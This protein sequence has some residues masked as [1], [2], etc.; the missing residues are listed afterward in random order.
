ME[1]FVNIE[2]VV[3]GEG[4]LSLEVVLAPG[5]PHTTDARMAKMACCRC[6]ALP[7]HTCINK[8]GP[9]FGSVIDSTSL[10]H[11]LEHLIIDAQ[12]HNSCTKPSQRFVGTTNWVDEGAGRAHIEVNFY[13]DLIALRA[14]KDAVAVLND[15]LSEYGTIR[16]G[17]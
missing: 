9:T 15:I 13:D 16:G 10:P 12:V 17:R 3:V 7:I 8:A 5:I 1:D 4:R 6:S 14:V 2:S 11:L